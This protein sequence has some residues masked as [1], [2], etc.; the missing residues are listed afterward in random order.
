MYCREG[1][2]TLIIARTTQAKPKTALAGAMLEISFA[3]FRAS[4]AAFSN[5]RA[6]SRSFSCGE[7]VAMVV[8]VREW[9]GAGATRNPRSGG[10]SF[11]LSG[12]RPLKVKPFD[13]GAD[14]ADV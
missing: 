1:E 7:F 12:Y 13:R 4:M 9:Y 14:S 8:A 5:E 6:L 2:R 10:R 3:R 11:D